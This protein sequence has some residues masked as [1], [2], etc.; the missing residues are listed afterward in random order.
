MSDGKM[1]ENRQQENDAPKSLPEAAPHAGNAYEEDDYY[2]REDA[3]TQGEVPRSP[4]KGYGSNIITIDHHEVI[5]AKS[6]P[7]E[8]GT[9]RIPCKTNPD[10]CCQLDGWDKETSVP[11]SAEGNV[12]DF[13]ICHYDEETDCWVLKNTP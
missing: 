12:T 2:A 4:G 10:L 6:D 7:E 9:L 11:V 13:F 3:Q 1:N 8:Q 5:D